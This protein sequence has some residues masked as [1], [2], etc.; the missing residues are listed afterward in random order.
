[1]SSLHLD[2]GIDRFDNPGPLGP[3]AAGARGQTENC[4]ASIANCPGACLIS[5]IQGVQKDHVGRR[6]VFDN[7][8]RRQPVSVQ[9]DSSLY[10]ITSDLFVLNRIE[11]IFFLNLFRLFILLLLLQHLSLIGEFKDV[12]DDGTEDRKGFIVFCSP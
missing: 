7:R 8:F 5:I 10:Q 11:S 6:N 9:S 4:N 12:A 3:A 2:K 1:M